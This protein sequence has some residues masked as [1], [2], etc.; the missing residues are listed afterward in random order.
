MGTKD[1]P[2]KAD[3]DEGYFGK[4]GFVAKFWSLTSPKSDNNFAV[5]RDGKLYASGGKIG[6]WREQKRTSAPTL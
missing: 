5:S 4:D 3:D 1:L 6:G 2:L